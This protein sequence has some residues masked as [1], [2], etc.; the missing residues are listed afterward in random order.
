M[1][2]MRYVGLDVHAETF[3]IA[4]C[5]AGDS[6]AV[7][8]GRY[9][10]SISTV[11]KVLRKLGAPGELSVAYEAGPTGYGLY[12]DLLALGIQVHVVAPTLIPVKTGDKV[13]TDR[14]DSEK[15]ARCLR[16]GDLT[17]VW[18]PTIETEALRDLVR[19]REDAKADELRARHRLSKFLLRHGRHRPKDMKKAWT[20]KHL[21][22]VRQQSFE[23]V[24]QQAAFEDY[25][26]EVEHCSVRV[27]GLEGKLV[28]IIPELPETHREVIAALQSMRGIAMLTSVTLVSEIGKFGRFENPR[29]LM[30][31]AGVVPSESSS[32]G[33]TRRGSITK[34][35]N[36]HV[37][38][39][40]VE[41]AW[42]ARY[43]PAMSYT[44]KRR[45][46]SDPRI[47]AIAWSAQKRLHDR[48]V[49][50]K[51]KGKNH[52]KVLI[53]VA[54]EMLGFIWE[55]ANT[56]EHASLR[57]NGCQTA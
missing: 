27:V 14:R 55:I 31:Y 5:D 41:A 57:K 28:E 12:R 45:Q 53:A 51:G 29:Q 21:R 49:C 17:D 22:W 8:V 20:I 32:G 25:I 54:R 38:R 52:N 3:S 1:G 36:A 33:S 34:T 7:Y 26:A 15:L 47:R 24:A 19:T 56:V 9:P 10:Y 30:S 39:V 2:N 42:S 50:L 6:A 46:S 4:V 40:L 35:G 48:Y 23:Q 11:R 13:K 16:S 18:V 37:R 43:K 44:I